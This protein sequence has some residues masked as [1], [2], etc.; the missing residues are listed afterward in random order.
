MLRSSGRHRNL[1]EIIPVGTV[2]CQQTDR[3]D[4]WEICAVFDV[5]CTGDIRKESSERQKRCD[6]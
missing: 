5:L 3:M 1:C 4:G 2:Q 6:I